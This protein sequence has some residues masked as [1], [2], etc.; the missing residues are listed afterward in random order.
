M[1][2]GVTCTR[3]YF[4]ILLLHYQSDN[5]NYILNTSRYKSYLLYYYYIPK[6]IYVITLVCR[7]LN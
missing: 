2:M 4:F 6:V 1:Y 5:Y 7:L 3:K